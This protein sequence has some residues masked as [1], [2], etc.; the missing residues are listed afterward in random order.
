MKASGFSKY[1]R[2][3]IWL[4]VLG[5]IT[6]AA[7]LTR[8]TGPGTVIAMKAMK[9]SSMRN[10]RPQLPVYHG[11]ANRNGSLMPCWRRFHLACWPIIR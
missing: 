10:G 4:T 7:T 11:Q 9:T 1:H 2:R 5:Q 8:L 6:P 3:A